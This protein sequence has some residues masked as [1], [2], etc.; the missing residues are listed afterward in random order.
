MRDART[1]A[2][3]RGAALF[4]QLLRSPCFALLSSLFR[5]CFSGSL[6]LGANAGQRVRN[7]VVSFM[8]GMFK[9]RAIDLRERHFGA[10]GLGPCCRVLNREFV[11]DGLVTGTCKALGDF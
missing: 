8:T 9:N 1:P 5:R 7:A 6:L 11:T 10:P 4:Q 3:P 2:L